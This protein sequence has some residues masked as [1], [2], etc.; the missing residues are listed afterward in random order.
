MRYEKCMNCE[1]PFSKANTHSVDGWRETQIS[2]L[3][4]NC[5]DEITAEAE[6]ESGGFD[7]D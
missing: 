7:C 6:E 1:Q 5:F 2:G 3:C 4:E